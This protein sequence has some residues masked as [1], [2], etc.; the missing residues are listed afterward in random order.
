MKSKIRNTSP[1]IAL[2]IALLAVVTMG[3]E[4]MFTTIVDVDAADFP[5]C[6]SVSATLDTDSGRFTMTLY[7]GRGFTTGRWHAEEQ[8]IVKEATVLLYQDD[9]LVYSFTGD[10]DLSADK[11]F[12]YSYE[13]PEEVNHINEL[14]VMGISAKA[15]STYRLEVESAGYAKVIST[16]VMPVD[17]MV[18]NISMDIE[19]PVTWNNVYSMNEHFSGGTYYPMQCTLKD[20]VGSQDYYALQVHRTV[21]TNNPYYTTQAYEREAGIG[22]TNPTLIQDNPDY[23]SDGGGLL[24]GGSGVLYQFSTL[25]ISDLTFTDGSIALD[26]LV[27]LK[28]MW[29]TYLERPAEY[30]PKEHG[31]EVIYDNSISLAVKHVTAETFRHYRS[32]VLQDGGM[33]FFTEPVPITSN[34]ENGYGCFSLQN[35]RRIVMKEYKLYRY[36]EW[37]LSRN[38]PNDGIYY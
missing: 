4:S 30:N 29:D 3:C 22:V 10:F 36:P 23:E 6:L 12:A 24:D 35:T 32:L 2:P 7:E 5:P 9:A 20:H 19:N 18:S 34:V 16:A 38:P 25:L 37:H 8:T 1:L 33:G 13:N 28:P 15:G 26:A 21:K 17:P 27:G 31:V 14:R 11:D